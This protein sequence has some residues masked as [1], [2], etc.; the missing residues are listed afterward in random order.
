MGK[1]EWGLV[2]HSTRI[3]SSFTLGDTVIEEE[4]P[5]PLVTV[6]LV[7]VESALFKTLT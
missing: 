2:Y 7:S 1:K 6:I 4:P 3:E 5:S